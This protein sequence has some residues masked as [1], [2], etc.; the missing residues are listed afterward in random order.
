MPQEQ[1]IFCKVI[2]GE[3]PGEVVDSDDHTLTVMD[4]NPATRGH[5]VVM[6]RTHAEN[7]LELSDEDL[8][9]AMTTVRRVVHRMRDTLDPDGFNILHNIGRAAWQSIFHF[10][11]HVIPRYKD[12]P[13]QLPWLPQ[14]ADPEE[15]KRVAAEIRG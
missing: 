9:A 7:L 6:T 10:H 2:A 1:C 15:L 3:I 11:V 5:V 8:M 13:L 12:D 14:P 4:I